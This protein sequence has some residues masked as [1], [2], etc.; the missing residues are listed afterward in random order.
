MTTLLFWHYKNIIY[1]LLFFPEDEYVPKNVSCYE[2]TFEKDANNRVVDGTRDCY[3]PVKY[4]VPT[5]QCYGQCQVR[6]LL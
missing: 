1:Y 6:V 3:D 2:C 5:V 4:N